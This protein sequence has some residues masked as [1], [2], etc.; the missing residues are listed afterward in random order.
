MAA[1]IMLDVELVYDEP[2]GL[3]LDEED[4][5]EA[6]FSSLEV[7]KGDKGDPGR[8]GLDGAPFTYDMFTP[9]QLESLRG[10]PGKDGAAGKDGYTPQKGID[11]FD[12]APGKDGQPGKDGHTPTDAELTAL[13][14][15]QGFSKFS[16]NYNDL[17]N[18]PTIPTT[19]AQVGAAPA[20]HTHE[21]SEVGAIPLS[22]E[23]LHTMLIPDGTRITVSGTDLNT[24][25]FL[26]VGKYYCDLTATVKTLVNCPVSMAFMME[27]YSPL[28]TTIDDEDKA[29]IY[30]VRVVTDLYGN[31]WVQYCNKGAADSDWVYGTWK[32]FAFTSD[33][34]AAVTNATV[35]GWGYIK[36]FTETDPTVPAWAK[37]AS[38]PTYTASE[39]G[40]LPAD[41]ELPSQHLFVIHEDDC[42]ITTDATKGVAPYSTSYGYT[43]VIVKSSAGVEWV[44]G[45]WYTFIINTKLVVSG[46]YRNV[47]ISMEG[48]KDAN[49]NQIWHPLMG[50]TTSII[51]GS[52]YFVKNMTTMFQYKSTIRTEGALHLYYD[53]NTTYA[54]LVNTIVGDATSSPITIDSTGYGARYSLIF[55]T[56]ADRTKWSS[57]VKSSGTGTTKAATPCTFYAQDPMY[58]YS[59]NVAAGAK[60]INSVYQYYQAADLRYTAN[61]SSTYLPAYDRAF[62]WLKDFN[63]ENKTFKADATVG[64]VVGGTK[65]G[66]RWASSVPGSVYLYWLGYTTATWYQLN[67]LQ[68]DAPRVWKYTPSTGVLE[69]WDEIGERIKLALSN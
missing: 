63:A 33:V 66:T 1:E 25:D 16:G 68:V 7:L 50:Y 32:K 29:W 12:G 15:A 37:A 6:S 27:V 45:A 20:S 67:P 64:N 17:T 9:E 4:V 2:M 8:D 40:A 26:R 10:A 24:L 34:P 56:T 58:I 42:T 53:A 47:R 14:I 5:I 31:K 46:T 44:E 60:P 54:Y 59:A 65:L 48:E 30:R 38:K 43:N 13:I 18:K 52:T 35:A 39:V 23:R 62:L 21:A 51:A 11:Y 49:G 3:E 57:L 28:S 22:R 61:T 55:P 36:S 19:P 69:P 41:T